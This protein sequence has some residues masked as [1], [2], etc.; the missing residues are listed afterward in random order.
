MINFKEYFD[1]VV[2]AKEVT[3]G[4]YEDYK[5]KAKVYVN[6]RASDKKQGKLVYSIQGRVPDTRYPETNKKV[7][8][9]IGYNNRMVLTDV[10]FKVSESS[11]QRVLNTG[12]KNVHSMVVG[13]I[14]NEEPT[15]LSTKITYNPIKYRYFV[16]FDEN[17][18]PV[19]IKSAKKVAFNPEGLTAEGIEDMTPENSKTDVR[20]ADWI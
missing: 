20:G 13:T 9:V 1:I 8:K 19:P 6:L 14:S 10:E 17:G 3:F 5:G 4:G 12:R 16:R 7:A 2:E 15:T 18:T 11:R